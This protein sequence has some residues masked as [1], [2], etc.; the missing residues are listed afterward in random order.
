MTY[1]DG[2][3]KRLETAAGPD[4]IHAF[5]DLFGPQYL[6]LAVELGGCGGKLSGDCRTHRR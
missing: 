1:G 4:G 5:I 2:L 6:D 3:R